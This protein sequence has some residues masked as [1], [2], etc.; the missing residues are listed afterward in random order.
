VVFADCSA[1]DITITAPD[2]KTIHHEI[3][4]KRKSA[5]PNSNVVHVTSAALIDGQTTV[6]LTDEGQSITIL[7]TA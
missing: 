4:I 6:D 7:A 5:P 3:V 1:A 2:P